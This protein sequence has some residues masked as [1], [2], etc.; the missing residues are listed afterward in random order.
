MTSDFIVGALFGGAVSLAAAYISAFAVT[1]IA[2]LPSP[3]GQTFTP[4][5]TEPLPFFLKTDANEAKIEREY[6][7]AP[8]GLGR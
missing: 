8:A 6:T 2:R 1:R 5:M 7:D 3:T 4:G